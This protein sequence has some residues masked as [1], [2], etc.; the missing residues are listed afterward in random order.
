M[1]EKV[2]GERYFELD[3]QLSEIKRQLRQPN[4][5]P[6]NLEML[7]IHLQK[8]VEG[9]FFIGDPKSVITKQFDTASFFDN[10]D[11]AIWRGPVDGNGFSGEEDIDQRSLLLTEV[12]LDE[13]IFETCIKKSETL[14]SVEEELR[15]LK[16]EKPE[17]IRFG[18]NVLLGLIEDFNINKERSALEWI[19]RT[20]KIS[21]ID[22]LGTIFRTPYGDRSF[23]Y[24]ERKKGRWFWTAS[25]LG[26]SWCGSDEP[27]IG[28]TDSSLD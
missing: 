6:F 5:Y 26:C 16:E 21:Q 13:F 22:F 15:R 27:T 17:F 18:G 11:F 1:A 2:T 7:K 23:L 4:G 28:C 3:G 12:K 8:A 20:F 24:L 9:R 25:P 14:I 19:Y 10:K